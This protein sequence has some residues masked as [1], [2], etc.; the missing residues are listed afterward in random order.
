MAAGAEHDASMKRAQEQLDKVID[1][2]ARAVALSEGRAEYQ[3]MHDQLTTPLTS[4]YKYRKGSTEGLQQL[5]DKYKK[6]AT[7][8][9]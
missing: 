8:T 9:P 1:L 6:P 5:I 2:Y 4:Y 7:V 3:P